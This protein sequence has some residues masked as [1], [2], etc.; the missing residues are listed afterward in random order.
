MINFKRIAGSAKKSLSLLFNFGETKQFLVLQRH[1]FQR[2]FLNDVIS[3]D[4]QMKEKL[5]AVLAILAVLCSHISSL[6]LFKYLILRDQ[7][8]SWVEKCY[9]MF[10]F[11]LLMGLITILEWDVIFLD[12]RDFSNLIPLP[13]KARTLFFA[14]F[15]SLLLFISLFSIAI[16]SMATFVFAYILPQWQSKSLIYLIR[17]ILAHLLSVFAS[18]FFVFFLFAFLIGLLM[19]VLGYR[20]FNRISVYLRAL[21]MA[22]IVFLMILY[23]TEF[24]YLSKTFA[25]FLTLKEKNSLFLQ[26]FPPMWF[27]GLYETLLGSKDPLF[28]TLAYYGLLAL[29]IPVI[30]FFLIAAYSYKKYIK[31]IGEV[32][33]KAIHLFRF[34]KLLGDSFNAIFLRNPIQRAVFYFF[35][36]MLKRSTLHKMRLASYLAVS[37]GLTLIPLI[38]KTGSIKDFASVS[39]TLL[40]I[41]LI[42]SFF[43]LVGI[44]HLVSIPVSLEA[45]WV[46]RLTE[47]KNRKH[48]FSG[49]KKGIFLLTLAPLFFLLFGFYSLLWGWKIAFLHCLYGLVVSML[50]T[51]FLFINCRKIPF[52]C[53]Y[54]PGKAKIHIFWLVYLIS[55]LFYSFYLS[56]LE[57]KLLKQPSKFFIFYGACGIM[58][59]AFK[60]YKRNFL[61]RKSNII[62]EEK[63][64]PVMVTL[65]PY[66]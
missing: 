29:I 12:S 56:L 16:N 50:L 9:I 38:L 51:E 49:L 7:G 25:S 64:E 37:A 22:S 1:F 48:Y 20:I 4:V 62:Y 14:K 35:E 63:P 45:N 32:G 61:Y 13:I 42:L 54:L 65:V 47:I 28:L 31:K 46:F 57:Y 17:F 27:V 59:A 15:V 60:I 5:I 53:S 33:R 52:T 30:A 11:M 55:F 26:L 19:S 23:L 18:N 34:K 44:R 66:D 58:F 6:V 40:S 8:T 39:K 3:F 10:F 2:L 21:M 41:P 43:L 36:I 24:S